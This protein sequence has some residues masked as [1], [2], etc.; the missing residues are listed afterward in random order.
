M[1]DDVRLLITPLCTS[2][3]PEKKPARDG[4]HREFSI[5]PVNEIQSW[6]LVTYGMAIFRP[7]TVWSSFM[8]TTTVGAGVTACA[9]GD[10]EPVALSTPANSASAATA[11]SRGGDTLPATHASAR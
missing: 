2:Y 9:T 5:I 8:C 6:R 11:R 7:S 1:S 10:D 3:W 4:Q